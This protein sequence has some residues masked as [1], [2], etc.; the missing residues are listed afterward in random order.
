MLITDIEQVTPDW[1]TDV[2]RKAGML[3]HGQVTGVEK[4]PTTPIRGS[5]TARLGLSYSPETLPVVPGRLFLKINRREAEFGVPGLGR[6]EPE[7]YNAVAES[8]DTLPVV[9]CYDAVY[10]AEAGGYHL[11]L[12]DLSETHIAFPPSQLPPIGA[13]CEMIIDA[14]ADLHAYWW[15]HPRLGSGVGERPTEQMLTEEFEESVRKFEGFADFL[16]D[17]LSASRRN[18]YERAIASLSP[19]VSKRFKGALTLTFEDVHA[20]N[21]LY[22]INPQ[23]DRLYIIDW[24]QW[25]VNMGVSDLAYMMG[26][27]WSPER[28]ARLEVDYLRRYHQRLQEC[29]VQ[30]YSWDD[31]WYDY[32]LSI[33][34]R[35]FHPAWQWS[36][37]TPPDIWWN[38]F[39][40]IT[41]AYED[42]HC[43]ELL[44]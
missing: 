7:F 11:L 43:E 39:E 27:F 8:M 31:C 35:I 15:E 14:L 22:P 17:R 21:F 4:N 26:M 25:G 2:L 38:H 5:L 24:E 9:P 6:A 42:L 30:N 3:E 34:R 18:M 37:G 16:G 10:S 36:H 44:S 23:Q 1:L 32:R 28:R 41:S 40:R 20:G 13:Y 19:L 12:A 29:G 33:T